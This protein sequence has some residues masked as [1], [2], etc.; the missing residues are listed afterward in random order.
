MVLCV[1]M[2]IHICTV[3]QFECFRFASVHVWYVYYL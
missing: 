2:C 1:C 3:V